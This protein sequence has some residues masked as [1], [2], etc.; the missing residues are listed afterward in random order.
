[1]RCPKCGN[2]VYPRIN[3]AVIVGVISRDNRILVTQYAPLHG[4]YRHDALVAGYAEIGETI[5]ECVRREVKEET[6]ITVTNLRYYKSQPWSFSGS[7]LF[8][9]FCDA[10]DTDIQLDKE[11]LRSAVFKAPSD[12][13]DIPGHASLTG[14]MIQAFRNG[15]VAY[16]R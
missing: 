3:P 9:F 12:D 7:L 5:E 15:S 13:Y 10:V 6:G 11:E 16:G 2:L 8:G 1:M 14:D 4:E